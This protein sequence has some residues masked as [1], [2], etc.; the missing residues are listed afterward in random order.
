MQGEAGA[1]TISEFEP[2]CGVAAIDKVKTSGAKAFL[3]CNFFQLVD[4]F[5]YKGKGIFVDIFLLVKGGCLVI[6][7]IT[8]L[9]VGSV[10]EQVGQN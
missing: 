6:V 4:G 2:L 3:T 8:G 7:V 5:S 9:A 10:A 1:K